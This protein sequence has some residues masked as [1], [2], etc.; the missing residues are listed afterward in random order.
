MQRTGRIRNYN[1]DRGF[2][3][4]SEDGGGKNGGRLDVFFHCRALADIFNPE[5]GM[6][7]SFNGA[8][9]KLGR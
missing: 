2:G 9:D 3:F 1:A 5:P 4:I 8:T 6:R 7:V